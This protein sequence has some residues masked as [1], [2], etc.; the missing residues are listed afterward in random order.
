MPDHDRQL[1]SQPKQNICA[2]VASGDS[3]E[4]G[5]TIATYLTFSSPLQRKLRFSCRSVVQIL[6]NARRRGVSRPLAA[7]IAFCIEKAIN[8]R[9]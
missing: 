3:L 6:H 1:I 8:S 9:H 4:D 2:A 5:T 7:V